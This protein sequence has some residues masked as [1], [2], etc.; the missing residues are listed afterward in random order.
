[1]TAAALRLWIPRVLGVAVCAFLGLFALD[2]F[3]T[4]RGLAA[5]P[6]FLIHLVPSLLLL[7]VVAASWRHPWVGGVAFIGLAVAYAFM[8]RGRVDW[9]LVISG[10]LFIV[11][12][13]FLWAWSA[14]PRRHA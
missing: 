7:A 14:A 8:V 2:A 9:I 12:V 13:L 1:M 10:P 4:G 5:L 11:G 6:D 3:S